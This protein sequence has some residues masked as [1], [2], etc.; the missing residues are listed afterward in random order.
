[1]KSYF[2]LSLLI[3]IF[4]HSI[5]QT[6][7]GSFHLHKFAQNIGKETYHLSRHTNT[8]TYDIDFK[9]VDRGSAVPLQ[10]QLVTTTGYDPISLFIKG[11][12]SRFSTINDTIRIQNKNVWVRVDDSIHTEIVKPVAFPVGGYSPGTVQAALLQYWKKH[13]EPKNL[14]LLPTG[15]VTITRQG[16]DELFFMNKQLV[17]ER[18]VLGGLVWGNEIVWTDANGKLICLITNDAEGDK[19]E[20]METDHESLLPELISRAATYGMQLFSV[21]MKMDVSKNKTIAI[22]GGNII[23]VES[24][25]TNSNQTII[26]ENGLIKQIGAAIIKIPADATIIHAEGKTILPGLWDMH[27]HF[28]QAEWGPAYLAAGGRTGRD[29]GNEIWYINS[30]KAA[31]DA[32]KGVGPNILKAG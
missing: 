4:N 9:F 1:M 11:S 10:A 5:A 23:D 17:L 18:Y 7:S 26:I 12:T 19:L 24:S 8:L 15:M 25:Q 16:K 30:I 32:H 2:S 22:V 31:I 3:F 21:A 28:E 20:M 6:D 14:S 27:S 13:G 29:C